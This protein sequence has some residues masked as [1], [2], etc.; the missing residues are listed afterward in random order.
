MVNESEAELLQPYGVKTLVITQGAAGAGWSA[1]ASASFA[2]GPAEARDTTG[3]GDTFLAVML[4]SAL[5]R[6]V[7]PDDLALAHAS[8]AAAIT[9]S[10]RGRSAPFPMPGNSPPC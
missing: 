10:R 6:D 3:A 8:R 4:A 2:R 9:V 5:L 7:E 1:M